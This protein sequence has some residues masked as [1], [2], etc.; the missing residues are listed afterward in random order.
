MRVVIAY[1]SM[2]GN[3][4]S[5]AEAIASGFGND[6]VV[7]VAPINEVDPADLDADVLIIGAPTHAHGL[8]RPST[9][10]AA[11]DGAR[12]K[13]DEHR[14]DPA[15]AEPECANGYRS[16]RPIC[17]FRSPPSTPGSVHLVARGASRPAGR[18]EAAPTRSV[19]PG[20]AR[21]FLRGQA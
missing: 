7:T 19:R 11:A 6:H 1:E 5:V 13:Y 20:T 15:A 14:L 2:Y 9:R 3:T 17:P 21:E 4:H 10:R 18:P 8:P 16:C 12:T